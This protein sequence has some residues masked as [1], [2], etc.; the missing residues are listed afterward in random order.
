MRRG[1]VVWLLL[2]GASAGSALAH[3]SFAVFFQTDKTVSVQGVVT[4]FR[5]SNPHGLIRLDVMAKD[6][7]T[8]VWTAETNSPS[9]LVRRGWARDSL[10]AGE[11]ITVEGWPARDGSH[12]LRMQKAIR[13]NGQVIG[14]PLEPN[15]D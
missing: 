11:R 4:E 13:E 8:Q 1:A 3:H 7:S 6:G 9:I 12:Y 15:A 10:K 5:F 2:A 14:K